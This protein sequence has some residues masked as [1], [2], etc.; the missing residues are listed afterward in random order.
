[1]CV[2]STFVKVTFIDSPA[3]ALMV[4]GLNAKFVASMFMRCFS[5]P[6]TTSVTG[7]S[8]SVF[9]GSVSGGIFLNSIVAPDSVSSVDTPFSSVVTVWEDDSEDV[10]GSDVFISDLVQPTPR[11]ATTDKTTM[12]FFIGYG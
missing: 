7:I 2:P 10:D 11:R 8:F 9:V 1:M 6:S 5:P 4:F 12:I 3:L